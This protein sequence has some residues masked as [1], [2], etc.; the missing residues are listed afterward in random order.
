MQRMMKMKREEL[1]AAFM[2][3]FQLFAGRVQE[4]DQSCAELVNVN[5]INKLDL[6][7]IGMIG[8][9]EEVIMRD[10]AEFLSIP[11]STATGIVDKLV[12][13][14]ILRRLHSETD[15]RT[16]KIM[17]TP[18][19]GQEIY[20]QFITFRYKLGELVLQNLDERDLSD[21]H[22][23]MSKMLKQITN[24]QSVENVERELEK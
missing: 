9:R 19:K 20:Q 4:T 10:V 24:H 12:S 22:R 2:E 21:L 3:T 14:K 13:K 23:I 11:Q 18:R 6:A 15:R 1:I 7:L 17:L 5:S 16:V 8:K